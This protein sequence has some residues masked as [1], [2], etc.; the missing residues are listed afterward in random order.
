MD[1]S[2]LSLIAALV[3]F[4]VLAAE[5]SNGWSDAPVGTSAAVASGV[6]TSSQALRVTAV[7][8][9]LGV[10]AGVL[11]GA[12]VAKTIGTGI[13]RP[14]MV[15]IS[16]I[17]IAMGT[18]IA[19]AGIALVLGLPVSKTHSL[20]AA[21]AGIGFAQGG[22]D[23]L[24]P[25]SG[26]WRDSGWVAVGIGMFLAIVCG[27]AIAWFAASVVTKLGWHEK[28]TDQWWRRLQLCTVWGVSS[29]HGFNDGLK[30]AGIFTLVLY[31]AGAI[32]EFHVLPEVIA[33]CAV[34]MGLGTLL[35]GWRIHQRLD[36]MVNQQEQAGSLKKPFRPYMG[37]CA[38]ST[39]AF[40]IWQTG[41]LGIPMSTNHGVVSSMAGAKSAEGKV[42]TSSIIRIVW[43]WV[44]T[45]VFCF[46]IA[47]LLAA[48]ML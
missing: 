1:W 24:T 46:I 37:V 43:G 12:A 25:A 31:K 42:H 8:N 11:L 39:S 13:V 30:Y 48:S 28:V 36:G 21:L 5:C 33:L 19:W 16:S 38:E 14:E 4:L 20:L 44:V 6:L 47:N 40:F 9:F 3:L 41:W 22:F 35:G 32:P 26:N 34:V 7:G 29:G 2:Q 15:S 45:Y 17:G 23:A 10:L 18:T 27:S